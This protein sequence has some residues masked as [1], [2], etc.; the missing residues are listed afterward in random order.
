MHISGLAARFRSEHV[1]SILEV[2]STY[3]WV[4]VHAVEI[5]SGKMVL[6]MEGDNVHDETEKLKL[7]QGIPG[8]ATVDLVYH[9]FESSDE[10]APREDN[11]EQIMSHL[12]Q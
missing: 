3:D 5:E 2:L 8:V 1:D 12:N 6:V 10:I 7:L 9:A 4:E 11:L